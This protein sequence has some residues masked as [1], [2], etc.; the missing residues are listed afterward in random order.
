MHRGWGVQ[1]VRC[2]PDRNWFWGLC[3]PLYLPHKSDAVREQRWKL[4][5]GFHR[6]LNQGPFAPES[7]TLT[8]VPRCF[9]TFCLCWHLIACILYLTLHVDSKVLHVPILILFCSHH[10]RC[11]L[12]EMAG[13]KSLLC[14]CMY[15]SLSLTHYSESAA[16]WVIHHFLS[17]MKKYITLQ[18]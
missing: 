16:I 14:V 6:E 5:L 9:S 1:A 12:Y 8:T 13:Y 10:T 2:Y 17:Y 15:I 18:Y 3:H 11:D 7:K 4:I